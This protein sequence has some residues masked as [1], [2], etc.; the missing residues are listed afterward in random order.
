MAC[1]FLLSRG[2]SVA[3]V[4]FAASL[5]TG[6]VIAHADEPDGTGATLVELRV[7][8]RVD[9]P[10]DVWISARPAGGD[11]DEL[12]T[13]QFP[14]A[15]DGTGRR[16]PI[17]DYYRAGDLAVAGLKITIAQQD[18]QEPHR[19][20]VSPCAHPPACG[21]IF[22]P[23]DDGFSPTGQYRYGNI[24]FVAFA[25]PVPATPDTLRADRE[26][27]LTLREVLADSDAGLNWHPALPMSHWTGVTIE[28]TPPR[29]TK[30]HLAGSDLRGELSG[31][32]GN[33]TGLT[34]LRLE[35]NRLDGSIPSKL[36]RLNALT[37][38][39]VGGNNLR[40]CVPP[41][42]RSVA[43]NDLDSLGLPNCP[44]PVD[45]W[46]AN[47][48]SDAG[49]L[50]AGTYRYETLLFDVPPGLQLELAGLQINGGL[51]L[52]LRAVSGD[53]TLWMEISRNPASF[54][55]THDEWFDRVDESMWWASDALLARWTE[56]WE[57]E[58]TQDAGGRP[59]P[60]P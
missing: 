47:S 19:I 25:E 1:R 28:G 44:P 39:Y 59:G 46:E 56:A 26:H 49:I 5:G 3:L 24:T 55:K 45:P 48:P 35:G 31:L 54:R 34:E 52:G 58:S 11:W 38:L 15:T 40:G 43:N 51:A 7:W 57:A 8:Q 9:D 60:V 22:V 50:D 32:L 23:L 13:F 42:L 4:L 17:L 6:G 27:L 18:H 21:L 53:P 37:H 33:L 30:V 16:W 2:L 12:G 41:I 29:V 20:Y 10:L 14:F 36:L